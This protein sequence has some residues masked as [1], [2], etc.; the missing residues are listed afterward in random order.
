MLIK[1]VEIADLEKAL[2]KVNGQYDGNVTFNNCTWVGHNRHGE[3]SYRVTL[4]VRDSKGR[5]ASRTIHGRRSVG[6]CWHVHGL[7]FDNLPDEAEIVTTGGGERRTVKP[8]DEWYDWMVGSA[9]YGYVNAS[10]LCE[11][12]TYD[13]SELFNRHVLELEMG[14]DVLDEMAEQQ[15]AQAKG[16]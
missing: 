4:R 9:Y 6:A 15:I 3:S 2:W 7:F 5:G 11:C 13:S 10:S 14:G 8:G 1:N 16:E 12:E